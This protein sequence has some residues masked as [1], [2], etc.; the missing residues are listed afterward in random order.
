MR[1]D[2]MTIDRESMQRIIVE[3]SPA[4]VEHVNVFRATPY[5]FEVTAPAIATTQVGD[6]YV[7]LSDATSRKV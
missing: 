7:I 5:E 6:K 1:D 3:T 4:V 2:K